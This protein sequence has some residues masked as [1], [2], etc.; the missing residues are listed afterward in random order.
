MFEVAMKT[1]L[2]VIIV[3]AIALG[4]AS[5]LGRLNNACKSGHHAWCA[6]DIGH[7]ARVGRAPSQG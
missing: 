7:H 4:A 5:M 1:P 2:V 6:S 3:A